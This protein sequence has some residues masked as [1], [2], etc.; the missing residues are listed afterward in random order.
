MCTYVQTIETLEYDRSGDRLCFWTGS[1]AGGK[2]P[3]VLGFV[4]SASLG[5]AYKVKE[6]RPWMSA[7]AVFKKTESL[8]G[9]NQRV[10]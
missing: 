4:H 3:V 7:I 1:K 10:K 8:G 2:N 6:S 9:E 5:K